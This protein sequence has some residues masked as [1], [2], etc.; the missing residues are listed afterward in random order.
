MEN[1]EQLDAVFLALSDR[2]RRRM[3]EGLAESSC[4]VGELA[5]VTGMKISAASKHVGLLEEAGLVLKGRRGREIVCHMNFDMWKQVA[6]YVSMH[7]QF[8]AG[9]LAELDAYLKEVEND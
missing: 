2:R 5:A 9:R 4:T 1:E 6:G 3:L 7:A 8:W